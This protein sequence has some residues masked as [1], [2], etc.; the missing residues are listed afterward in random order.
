MRNHNKLSRKERN[1]L[2]KKI[3]KRRRRLLASFIFIF[4]FGIFFIGYNLISNKDNNKILGNKPSK[5]STTVTSKPETS[6][7]EPEDKTSTTAPPVDNKDTGYLK[8][9]DDPNAEDAMM[10]FHNTEGLLKGTKTYPVRTDGKKVVYLTFDDGPSTTNTPK[11]LDILDQYNVKATFFVLGKSIDTDSQSEELLKQIANNGHAIGNH[12]YSHDYN[13][14]YPGRIIS[15]ENFMSDI[16]KC[17]DALKR[18]LGEDFKTRVVRFP[19]GYWSWDGRTN[20]RPILDEQ[21]YAIIDWNTLNEDAQGS[22]KDANQL[23]ECTKKNTEALGPN[24]DSIVLLMHDTY[25][26]EATVDALP[27][28]IEYYKSL[29]F[30]F[31]TIK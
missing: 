19:G 10:V 18:V 28:I 31:K 4:V 29:G 25:G 23:L 2:R 12:S 20:I 27:Q 22:K 14:L 26:K 6:T 7:T 30:E 15:P 9:E 17:N 3:I 1:I 21:G 24:A 16:N 8:L 11:V 13:Y 5:E